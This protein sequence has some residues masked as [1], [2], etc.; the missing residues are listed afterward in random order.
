MNINIASLIKLNKC[1]VVPGHS[2]LTKDGNSEYIS[3][4]SLKLSEIFVDDTGI[5]FSANFVHIDGNHNEPLHHHVS[6]IV[7]GVVNGEAT[8]QTPS[9][10]I[11]VKSG[12]VVV[13]PQGVKHEFICED[14]KQMD[15]LAY[16]VSKS[17]LDFLKHY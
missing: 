12:D 15:Y 8:L 7:A 11:P 10:F 9:E 13:I 2:K 3:L 1:S 5:E 16:E 6:H 14:G 4:P 17:S